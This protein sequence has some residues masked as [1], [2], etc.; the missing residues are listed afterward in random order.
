MYVV[1]DLSQVVLIVDTFS[2][3]RTLKK[4][5]CS[6]HSFIKILGIGIEQVT[7]EQGFLTLTGSRDPVRVFLDVKQKMK[8]VW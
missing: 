1:D 2:F 5:A 8:M 6:P 3:K 7:Q 4:T